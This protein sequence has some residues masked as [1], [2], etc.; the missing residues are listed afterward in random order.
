MNPKRP[1][2]LYQFEDDFEPRPKLAVPRGF[3]WP[4]LFGALLWLGAFAVIAL[5]VL[6]STRGGQ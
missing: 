4:L 2:P 6:K 5:I 3:N 1:H